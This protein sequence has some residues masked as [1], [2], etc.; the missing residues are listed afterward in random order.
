[1]STFYYW[2]PQERQTTNTTQI[3]TEL[4]RIGLGYA[5]EDRITARG[6]DRGP[7]GQRGV[8]VCHG[9]NTDGRLGWWPDEQT[10]KHVPGT[11]AWCG[12]FTEDRPGPDGL[13]RDDAI[14][15]EWVTLDDGKAWLIPRARRFIETDGLLAS[16][17]NLPCRLTLNDTGDWV[18]GGVKARYEKLWR[19]ALEYGEAWSKALAETQDGGQYAIRMDDAALLSTAVEAIKT[20]YRVGAI[21]L[22]ML[23]VFDQE[24]MWNV[25][26][27]LID[28]RTFA[29]WAKKKATEQADGGG[30]F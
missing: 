28:Q 5:V 21:E 3:L 8:V 22:D 2:L 27:I 12:M 4:R 16:T 14:S 25:L 9:G 29:S 1:M 19:L 18:V 17:M 10:W 20:N 11:D 15:G 7:D 30:T 26:E 13:A 24:V 6:S 23:G